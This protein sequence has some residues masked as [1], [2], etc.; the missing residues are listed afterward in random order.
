[1]YAS[2][3]PRLTRSCKAPSRVAL[4]D[5]YPASFSGNYPGINQGHLPRDRAREPIQLQRIRGLDLNGF[6]EVPRH[7][8]SEPE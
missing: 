1:M 7:C 3:Q 4:L 2:T 6:N 8:R 5:P